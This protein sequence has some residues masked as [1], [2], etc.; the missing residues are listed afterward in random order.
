MSAPPADRPPAPPAPRV[1][2]RLRHVDSLR[3]VAALLVMFLHFD[4]RLTTAFAPPGGFFHFL[5]TLPGIV[6]PGRMGVMIF[7][8]VSGFVICRSFGEREAQGGS[9]RFL[10]R[11]ACRL[12]PAY[13]ASLLG[14]ALVWTALGQTLTGPLLAA[15]ATMAAGWLGQPYLLGVYWTLEIELLFYALCLGLYWLRWLE[16]PGV[17]AAGALVLVSLPRLLKGVDHLAGT[18]L[19]LPP[20]QP[21]LLLSLAVML[22]GT[23]FRLVYDETGGFRRGAYRPWSVGLL[24][25]V[26]LALIDVPDPQF[27]WMLLG[28]RAERFPAQSAVAGAVAV[29]TVWVACLRWEGR[30]LTFLGTVSY[31]LYLF[32]VVVL[33]LL[34]P[35]LTPGKGGGWTPPLWAGFLVCTVAAVALAAAVYRW[36]ERPAIALGK[37]LTSPRPLS[38]ITA[39]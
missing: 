2:L 7:F 28:L 33:E 17:L 1:P 21:T 5:H 38:S 34:L 11:R 24:A 37:R 30:T 23:L 26:A 18:H 29:F 16:R 32:H 36:V 25:L 14:G 10:V 39:T 15:N 27:K 35:V 20:G 9:R 3:A 12:Y 19:R 13:W 6:D 8:A 4:Q 22:W 31:S